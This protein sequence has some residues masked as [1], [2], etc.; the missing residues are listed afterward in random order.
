MERGS[1]GSNLEVCGRENGQNGEE[2]WL[3]EGKQ[4]RNTYPLPE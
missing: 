2:W 3:H 1:Q 4:L